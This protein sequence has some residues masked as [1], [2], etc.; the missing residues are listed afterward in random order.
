MWKP[1]AGICRSLAR[2]RAGRLRPWLLIAIAATGSAQELRLYV[3]SEAGDRIAA[4]QPVHFGTSGT[5]GA[6]VFLIDEKVRDQEIVGFG[7]SLLE[8]G[9]ICLKSTAVSL[10]WRQKVVSLDLPASSFTTGIW[11]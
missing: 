10:S 8:A 4:R 6:P 3:T 11:R 7:A 5:P 1:I 2:Q 9:M